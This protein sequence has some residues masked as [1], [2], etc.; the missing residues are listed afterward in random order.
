MNSVEGLLVRHVLTA[1]GTTNK[2][3]DIYDNGVLGRPLS[4]LSHNYAVVLGV[5]E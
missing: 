2:S 5:Q 3:L 4:E 1:A